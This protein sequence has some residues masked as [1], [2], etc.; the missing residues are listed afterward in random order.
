[1][2]LRLHV[3]RFDLRL[4]RAIERNLRAHQLHAI[5]EPRAKAT[6]RVV[7]RLLCDLHRMRARLHELRGARVGEEGLRGSIEELG[8]TDSE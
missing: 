6:L 3:G 4:L 7:A 8:L 5:D 1:M 2:R